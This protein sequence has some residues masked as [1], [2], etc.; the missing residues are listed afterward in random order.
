MSAHRVKVL[1]MPRPMSHAPE[2]FLHVSC[3]SLCLPASATSFR[4][5]D[6]RMF[7]WTTRREAKKK[8]K[9]LTAVPRP[10][11]PPPLPPSRKVRWP[12]FVLRVGVQHLEMRR[13]ACSE[14]QGAHFVRVY[15]A[16]EWEICSS[17]LR[18]PNPSNPSFL[19]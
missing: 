4:R 11:F 17:G 6:A 12:L 10:P 5:S 18:L 2:P 7:S 8:R 13:W 19:Q 14:D 3:V 1:H 9:R 15:V 16:V